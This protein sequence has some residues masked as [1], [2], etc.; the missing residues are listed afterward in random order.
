MTRRTGRP[1]DALDFALEPA[2]RTT[3]DPAKR[4]G[5]PAALF[6]ARPDQKR[7]GFEIGIEALRA[8]ARERPDTEIRFFGA[9][10]DELPEIDFPFVN[11]GVLS[12]D[13]LAE[14][15]NAAHVFL[16]FSLTNI[17]HAPLEAMA[18]GCAV[19]EADV[20]SVREMVAPEAC[21]LVA[22]D[23]GAVAA[24]VLALLA[25]AERRVR[26]ARNGRDAVSGSSWDQTAGQRE[27]LLTEMCFVR[28]RDRQDSPRDT[29]RAPL[30]RR[31]IWCRRCLTPPLRAQLRLPCCPSARSRRLPLRRTRSQLGRPR[32][33]PRCRPPRSAF[34]RVVMERD[35]ASRRE[36][37]EREKE[38]LVD[39]GPVVRRVDEDEIERT[40]P[41]ERCDL[42]R[43]TDVDDYS[44]ADTVPLEIGQESRQGVRRL[45]RTAVVRID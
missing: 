38:I 33:A 41:E 12:V 39:V 21:V 7:R 42:S 28:L 24:A 27:T 14:A 25:D 40:G 16:G 36:T 13:E 4:G 35:G 17:S 11:L 26:L 6:F 2:F 10:D 44:L 1:A 22:P 3:I 15:L 18:C 45:G 32:T 8:I 20:P 29:N 34:R 23:P 9:R 31:S 5:P 19:V 37:A 43:D 30:R